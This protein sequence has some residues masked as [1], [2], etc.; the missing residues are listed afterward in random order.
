M[1]QIKSIALPGSPLKSRKGKAAVLAA[2]L[3]AAAP[4]LAA[5][6]DITN[7]FT[8]AGAG[9]WTDAGNWT[10][11]TVP[12]FADLTLVPVGTATIG[13]GDNVQAG[14]V[15]VRGAAGLSMTD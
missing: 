7:L 8:N 4:A 14:Q 10:Y 12:T 11:G 5:V 3:A 1:R 9:A 13:T 15:L 2:M 6:P